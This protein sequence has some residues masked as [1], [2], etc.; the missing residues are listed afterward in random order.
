[1]TLF[2]LQLRHFFPKILTG[3]MLS[4]SFPHTDF[5]PMLGP[6]ESSKCSITFNVRNIFYSRERWQLLLSEDKTAIKLSALPWNCCLVFTEK[7]WWEHRLWKAACHL[8]ISTQLRGDG[9]WTSQILSYAHRS[10][11]L[12]NS[13]CSDAL[14]HKCVWLLAHQF[15]SYQIK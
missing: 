13:T 11:F 14:A 8:I 10:P 5:W 3:E 2:T 4:S 15:H 7:H 1:M 12:I 6:K 9:Q